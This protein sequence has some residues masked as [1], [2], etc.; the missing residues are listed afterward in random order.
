[1]SNFIRKFFHKETAQET[2]ERLKKLCKDE[3][4]S[5]DAQVAIHE[6]CNYL[7]GEDWYIVDPVNA[8]QANAIIVYTIERKYKDVNK[9]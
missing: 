9:K 5:M 8:E 4:G 6:L 3:Y 7:L 1:M 2:K